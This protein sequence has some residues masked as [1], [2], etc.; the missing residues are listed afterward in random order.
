MR[1]VVKLEPDSE[2]ILLNGSKHV[3]QKTYQDYTIAKD[4][5]IANIGGFCSYCENA[6]GHDCDLHV[7]HVQPKGLDK[8]AA[9]KTEWS[10]FLLA[11]QTCNGKANKTDKDVVLTDIHLPHRNN[12]YLSLVYMPA[13]VVIVNPNLKGE[14]FEHAKALWEL[15][16]LNKTP[17]TSTRGD[18]RYRKRK[19]DWELAER[20]L[21]KFRA[22]KAD[23]ETIVDLV[24]GYGGWSIWFTVFS[25]VDE[26]RKALIEQFPGTAVGCFDANNHYEP[27]PRN[28]GHAD[29]V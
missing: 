15:V 2:E 16:G 3:V 17:M 29:P 5:L 14:S 20:Y 4:P 19:E 8:Y 9:L 21:A 7:E 11:C 10:N 23:V 27:V 24:K 1:P 25:G 28:A 6:Y 12:T 13:G 26:V 18:K 22:K